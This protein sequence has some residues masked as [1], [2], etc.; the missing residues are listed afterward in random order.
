[1]NGSSYDRPTSLGRLLDLVVRHRGIAEVS[2][3]QRLNAVW[4]EVAGDRIS[5]RSYVRRLRDGVLE[6]GVRNSAVLEELSS[7]L[8]HD[9]L[10][11]I[12]SNYVDLKIQSLKF[13][14]VR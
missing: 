11:T 14:R 5:Q 10:S 1:M 4:A 6:I 8:K 13:V 2:G 9:L 12:Q 7:Y 3:Q